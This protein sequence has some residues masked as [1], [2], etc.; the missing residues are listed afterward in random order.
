MTDLQLVFLELGRGGLF[1]GTCKASNG[2]VMWPSLKAGEDSEVDFF[3]N[4]IQ[5]WSL[6]LGVNIPDTLPENRTNMRGSY[7]C[8]MLNK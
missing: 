3:L 2:V 5:D 8:V 6:G 1:E 7:Q 4:V